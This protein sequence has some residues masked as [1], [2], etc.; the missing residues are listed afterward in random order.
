MT[1]L[2][3]TFAKIEETIKNEFDSKK[4]QIKWTRNGNKITGTTDKSCEG[5]KT[6]K[7]NVI[8][9]E[10]ALFCNSA[11]KQ[12]NAIGIDADFI[13]SL[14][15]M[16]N[17]YVRFNVRNCEIIPVEPVVDASVGS[18]KAPKNPAAKTVK[19]DTPKKPGVI[20][21]ILDIIKKGPQTKESIIDKLVFLFPEREAKAMKKTV[22]AQLGTKQPNR[23]EQEKNVF[24]IIKTEKNITTYEIDNEKK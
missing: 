22:N 17:F 16:A 15:P 20:T 24:M 2:N 11:V 9:N 14:E 7:V 23:M 1:K 12:L 3:A 21:S 18:V 10:L 19:N 8:K 13:A 5:L 4:Y 6:L